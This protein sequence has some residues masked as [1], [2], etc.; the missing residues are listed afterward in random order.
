MNSV[1]SAEPVLMNTSMLTRMPK[2][3]FKSPIVPA[4][5][6]AAAFSLFLFML[7]YSAIHVGKFVHDKSETLQT[8]DFVRLKR[9]TEVETLSRRKPPPPPAQPPPPSKMRVATETVQQGM[10]GMEIPT[11][12]LSASVSGGPMGGSIGAG[13]AMFDGD[14]LPL[15]R[16][17]PQYPRDAAR[18][19]ITGWVQ[20]EVLV[21]ADG[22]VR[23]AKVLDAKPKGIFEA[24]AVQAVMR[25][26]FKPK[27]K[28]GK[29]IEQKGSQKIEFN[30]NAAKA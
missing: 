14:L 18:A 7:M 1:A 24:S 29:P 11:L 13:A 8:I 27:I 9:D 6:M 20:L 22:S 16:I 10:T 2:I 23:G 12:N 30:I 28:D 5:V 19:G 15:Q 21:N 25:W 4:L 3:T 26:K 17:P